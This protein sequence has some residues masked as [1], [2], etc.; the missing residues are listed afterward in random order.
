MTLPYQKLR[1]ILFLHLFA[2]AQGM[3]DDE[4]TIELVMEQLKISR[5]NALKGRDKARQIEEKFEILDRSIQ[6][7]VVSYE[8]DRI[9]TVE[10]TAL[11]LGAYEIL[12]EPELPPKVAIAEA[13]RLT[14]KFGTPAA[15]AF[16]NALLDALYKMS[17][18]EK[19]NK[20]A[21]TSSA[22]NLQISE[23]TAHEISLSP[24]LD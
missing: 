20:Q 5:S 15:T 14:K 6:G 12:F 17:Q 1:E 16:V 24:P 2:K 22:Q 21:I 8:F 19:I 7:V 3:Q 23:Q 18:G 10:K 13:L 9:Q 4:G 11:R